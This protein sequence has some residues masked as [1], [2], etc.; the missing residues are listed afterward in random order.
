MDLE[1]KKRFLEKWGKYF[2]G[3]ELP[4]A[5]F[6]ADELDGVEFTDAPKTNR[7]HTCIFSQLVPVRRG[8]A[9]AFNQNNVGCFGAIDML[10][11]S[12]ARTLKEI[13]NSVDFLVHE[14]KFYKTEEQVKQI[15]TQ[16][17]PVPAQGKYIIFKHW[18]LLTENDQPLVVSFFCKPDTIA[19]LHALANYDCMSPFG[20]IAPFSSGCDMLVGFAIRELQSDDPKAVLGLFDPSARVCVKPDI[21]NFSI[22]WPKFVSMLENMDGCFLNTIAWEP[23]LKRM[24]PED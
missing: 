15:L 7:D 9:R 1:I 4:I 22:P 12:G 24:K 5:S 20:V 6:Y 17:Q 8:K 16:Y 14:E 2:P 10:G 3:S 11:F 19:G 23:I 21:L 18:D 13:E